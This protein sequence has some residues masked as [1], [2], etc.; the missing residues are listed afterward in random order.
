MTLYRT[1][2]QALCVSQ[3][4]NCNRACLLVGIR[5]KCGVPSK[6]L[7]VSASSAEKFLYCIQVEDIHSLGS[8]RSESS[9]GGLNHDRLGNNTITGGGSYFSLCGVL[10]LEFM[11]LSVTELVLI[12]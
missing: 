2:S 11:V 9:A 12:W 10:V 1:A 4:T 5:R 7:N 8:V 3:A 6:I